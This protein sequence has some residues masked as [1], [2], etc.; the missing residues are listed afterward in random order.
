MKR[1]Y[2]Y[3]IELQGFVLHVYGTRRLDNAID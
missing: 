3:D 2:K 1:I